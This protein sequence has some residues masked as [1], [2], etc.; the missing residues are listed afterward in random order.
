MVCVEIWGRKERFDPLHLRFSIEN[1]LFNYFELFRLL[2]CQFSSAGFG[3][4]TVGGEG[5]GRVLRI[6][7]FTFRVTS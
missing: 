2:P 6:E 3:G 7:F 5:V 1:L 4:E